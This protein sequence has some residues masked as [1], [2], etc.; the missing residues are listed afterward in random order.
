MSAPRRLALLA[1][2]LGMSLVSACGLIEEGTKA[3]SATTT[4]VAGAQPQPGSGGGNANAVTCMTELDVF[5]LAVD[6]YT[7]LEGGPPVNEA[8][9]VP[10]WL[11]AESPGSGC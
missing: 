9:L 8:A 1:G 2:L 4:T 3:I 5:Q 7:I 11:R 6:S 10:D